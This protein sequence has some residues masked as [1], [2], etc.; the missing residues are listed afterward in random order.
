MATGD[1]TRMH[2]S[3]LPLSNQPWSGNT[4]AHQGIRSLKRNDLLAK[5][6]PSSSGT[7]LVCCWWMAWDM[8]IQLT[9]TWPAP[10]WKACNRPGENI[11]VFLVMV[12]FSPMTTPN[13]LLFL[14]IL[15][16]ST[17]TM[18][19]CTQHSR[20]GTGCGSHVGEYR[21]SAIQSR[22]GIWR[23]PLDSCLEAAYILCV[24]D[25]QT[26]HVLLKNSTLET[27]SLYT[28]GFVY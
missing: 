19:N 7:R 21:T 3:L 25:I 20:L 6:R 1:E 17:M 14:T 11:L 8:D 5:C 18:P 10:H 16:F 27:L 4:L 26:Y 15:W 12:Q 22:F 23:F 9:L 24:R 28:V 13:F 2:H